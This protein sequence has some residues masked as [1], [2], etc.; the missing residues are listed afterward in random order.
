MKL[1]DKLLPSLQARLIVTLMLP[2]VLLSVV[3][4]VYMITVRHQDLTDRMV[5]IA[6]N[7]S[8]YLADSSG[9]ALFAGDSD[10]LR[11][12]GNSVMQSG[13]VI[14]VTFFDRN[15]EIVATVGRSNWSGEDL[16]ALQ[17]PGVAVLNGNRWLLYRPIESAGFVADDFDEK[18]VPSMY[19]GRVLVEL[20]NR[21][22]LQRQSESLFGIL[23]VSAVFLILSVLGAI[24]I[25][26]GISQPLKKLTESVEEI[27]S[28]NHEVVIPSQGPRE[29]VFL[30]DVLRRQ[31]AATRSYSQR[32]ERDVEKATAQLLDAMSDLE[33]AMVAKD[34]F[35]AKMSHELRTPLTAVIG[36]TSALSDERQRANREEYQRI[37]ASS[38]RL[39]L[40]T[41][42]D[43]LEFAR[44]NSGEL[45]LESGRLSLRETLSDV[46]AIYRARAEQ[47][48]IH[49]NLHLEPDIPEH[50][51]GD[52]VRIAQIFNN[53]IGNA[54]KFTR[55]GQID[56][57]VAKGG[58][59]LPGYQQLLCEVE[60]TGKGIAPARVRHLFSPFAQEDDSISRQFGGSG[61]GLAISRSLVVLMGGEIAI[62]SIEDQGTTVSFSLQL[63]VINAEID[64][65][66]CH[67]EMMFVGKR[68]LIAEDH[69]FNQQL[70]KKMLAQ[71]GAEVIAVDN[72]A[73]AL[74]ALEKSTFDLLLLDIHMP[75]MDGV[76]TAKAV[77]SLEIDCPIIVGLT[78]DVNSAEHRAM[79]A[80]GATEVL[81]KP[82]ERSLLLNTLA[83]LLGQ[84]KRVDVGLGLLATDSVPNEL[85]D[86][87][88]ET[89]AA[90]R[91]A[92]HR[93][94]SAAVRG[95]LHD[96]MGLSGLYGMN[97]LRK[98]V[99][100]LRQNLPDL[101]REQIESRLEELAAAV[102]AAS[103][104]S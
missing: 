9:F 29:L 86:T 60:D 70:L 82:I 96:L 35:M 101:D 18:D 44:S 54:L 84:P 87:L 10:Q 22:L 46:T 99:L 71:T 88:L 30:A 48:N 19:F 92:S 94:D 55:S 1:V 24:Q 4:T 59:S 85:I 26:R 97:D 81:V 65:I 14:A 98:L 72:G 83:E 36:F 76:Q 7:S 15:L 66:H 64:E 79:K 8:R 37:I 39:L 34:Q 38:S 6:D 77:S 17:L 95:A 102:A 53:L 28:G 75:V 42:D 104:A 49:L 63:A 13:D 73:V 47:K 21:I 50:L 31:I 27:E 33:E 103:S 69:P 40:K 20:D 51:W 11:S 58:Q 90:L 78:A 67:D 12:L 93:E 25:S 2:L 57:R 56:V 16:A 89:L 45:H 80:A 91:I 62:D 43:V 61:L 68:I 3:L 23:V 32:L 74:E 100:S 5:S 41:I 52:S